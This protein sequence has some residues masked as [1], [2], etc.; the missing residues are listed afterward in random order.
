MLHH[1]CTCTPVILLATHTLSR[2]LHH[3]SHRYSGTLLGQ[4]SPPG[5]IVVSGVGPG[6]HC[7]GPGAIINVLP[8]GQ[9]LHG[10]FS[11]GVLPLCPVTPQHGGTHHLC[12]SRTPGRNSHGCEY[13]WIWDGE[14]DPIN[15][16]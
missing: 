3:P 4:P 8:A 2:P 5:A 1:T 13:L 7:P 12:G 16:A 15:N 10:V 9:C 14:V 11:S 6:S